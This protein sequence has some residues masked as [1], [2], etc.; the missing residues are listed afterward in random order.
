MI[1]MWPVGGYGEF[2]K[3]FTGFRFGNEVIICDMG[4][5]TDKLVSLEEQ[6]IESPAQISTEELIKNDAIPDDE[7]FF[8]E[9][10]YLV[11]AIII[12][13]AHLDHIWATM[14]LAEKYDCPII[15]TPFTAEVL[16]NLSKNENIKIPNKI[17]RINPGGYYNISEKL[18]VEFIYA[19]HSTPQTVIVA[20]HYEDQT[21]I[22]AVDWKF[23]DYPTL[24]KRTDYKR[25]EQLGE[26]KKVLA[27]VS[28][29]TRIDQESRTFSESLVKNMFKDILF[30]TENKDNA[31]FVTTF[32][33]HVA[34]LNM[35]V[36][37]AQEMGRKPVIMGRSINNYLSAAEKIN[38]VN[39]TKKAKLCIYKNQIAKMLKEIE[40]NRK[41]YFVICTGC[42]GE[43]NSVLSRIARD[44]FKF[45]FTGDDQVIFSAST[46]PTEVNAINRKTIEKELKQKGVRIFSEV[47][48]S[49]HASKEDLRDMIKMLKPK[50]FIPAHGTLDKL[51]AGINL[52]QEMGYI[53]GKTAHLLYNGH[54]KK[55]N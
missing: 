27:L 21:I 30:W 48:V 24:G 10:G 26:S 20:I 31:I 37:M 54:K 34:R 45:K 39:I 19:T 35:L 14:K 51:S 8:E 42:Q 7:D 36:N 43:P 2:G 18:K 4:V 41:H 6:G 28:D 22:Y 29:S 12:G 16:K 46:I 3:N 23:D 32:A 15:L 33:S 25:L 13:H 9:W 44:E 49:G 40:K 52:A 17:I 5:S 38:L 55:L 11:K 1:E 47:H 53:L 50:H